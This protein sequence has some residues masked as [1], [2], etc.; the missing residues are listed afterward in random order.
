MPAGIFF[1]LFRWDAGFRADPQP[2]QFKIIER[3][4]IRHI[5]QE[6]D[7]QIPQ[8]RQ[9][10][11]RGEVFNARVHIKLKI[12]EFFAFRQGTDVFNVIFCDDQHFQVRHIPYKIH[13]CHDVVVAEIQVDNVNAVG[14]RSAAFVIGQP[15]ITH[16]GSQDGF[17]IRTY[18][19]TGAEADSPDHP[20]FR[21]HFTNLQDP[22]F[23]QVAGV[24]IQKSCLFHTRQNR[25]QRFAVILDRNSSQVNILLVQRHRHA[26]E[27]ETV[28]KA[29]FRGCVY[30][31][32]N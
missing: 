32:G 14:E 24:Q 9:P 28:V 23:R 2:V 15:E 30:H 19:V 8:F 25:N 27:A 22:L 18:T 21:E 7:F 26:V 4:E 29:G 13:R 10:G 5:R 20:D 31:P 3:R 11:E 16:I 12:P 17:Y 1:H 6:P